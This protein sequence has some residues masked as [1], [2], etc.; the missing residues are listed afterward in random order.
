MMFKN[1]FVAMVLVGGMIMSTEAVDLR[2]YYNQQLA[3]LKASFQAPETGSEV[4]V[5]LANGRT[6]K[7][8]L[9]DSLV[10]GTISLKVG[11]EVKVLKKEQLDQASRTQFFAKDY[12]EAEAYK[13]TKMLK[14]K[15]SGGVSSA[16]RPS[17]KLTVKGKIDA[18]KEKESETKGEFYS[19]TKTVITKTETFPLDVMV[20][21]RSKAPATVDICWYFFQNSYVSAKKKKAVVGE[22]GSKTVTIAAGKFARE[23]IAS[24]QLKLVV[25]IEES[26]SDDGDTY[27]EHY[28]GNDFA[29]YVVLIKQDGEMLEQASS[30]KEFLSEEWIEK[31]DAVGSSAE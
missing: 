20:T 10:P 13:R 4:S 16:N 3:E 12:A 27:S 18:D 28:E 5:G 6:V 22:R 31:L 11:E 17:L 26:E 1:V 25:N 29:G 30:D 7:G 21:N 19:R 8:T 23:K 9:V 14:E 24:K 15:Q 2:A